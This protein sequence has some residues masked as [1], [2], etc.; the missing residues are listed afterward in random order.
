MAATSASPGRALGETLAR[1]GEFDEAMAHLDRAVARDPDDARAHAA[2]GMV[3]GMRGDYDR[4]LAALRRSV[5]LDATQPM[6][7][8]NLGMALWRA[9]EPEA[10]CARFDELAEM[11]AMY[12]SQ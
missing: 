4:A 2:I 1:L 5:A 9:G 7:L 12:D 6:V 3:H 11:L 8:N 10:A